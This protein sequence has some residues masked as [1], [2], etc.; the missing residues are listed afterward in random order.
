MKGLNTELC[1][2]ERMYY[3]LYCTI[4]FYSLKNVATLGAGPSSRP[5]AVPQRVQE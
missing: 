2:K 3:Y 5:S 4:P 1:E